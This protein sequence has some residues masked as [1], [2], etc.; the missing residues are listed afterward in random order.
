MRA[1]SCQAAV[2]TDTSSF[3]QLQMN[4]SI[5]SC[6]EDTF[7]ATSLLAGTDDYPDVDF[8]DNESCI[9]EKQIMDCFEDYNSD[10]SLDNEAD[11]F[12]ERNDYV[13]GSSPE[14]EKDD[15]KKEIKN[16]K[17]RERVEKMNSA[18]IELQG[19]LSLSAKTT[20]H[21][22]LVAA[23][24]EIQRLELEITRIA[25]R[26]TVPKPLG[27]KRSRSTNKKRPPNKFLQFSKAFRGTFLSLIQNHRHTD[28]VDN[29]E[30][31]K[32][33]SIIWKLLDDEER[34]MNWTA[35]TPEARKKCT[36][37]AVNMLTRVS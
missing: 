29:R 33:L 23:V 37:L 22:T 36:T 9:I 30:V 28:R 20:K 5:G 17:E 10:N 26:C 35:A 6:H 13:D 8:S 3:L 14:R 27:R 31:T 1:M 2:R 19:L 11:V 18:F 34:S 24:A 12:P 32:F 4:L 16:R 25:G 15:D 7:C 21:E